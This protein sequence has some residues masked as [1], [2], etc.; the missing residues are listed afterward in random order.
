M[1]LIQAILSRLLVQWYIF[2]FN[3]F[4]IG[5]CVCVCVCVWG[6]GGGGGGGGGA[7]CVDVGVF[8]S[9]RTCVFHVIS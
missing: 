7:V 5:A 1:F 9:M 4:S 8:A 2:A 3:C 6:G